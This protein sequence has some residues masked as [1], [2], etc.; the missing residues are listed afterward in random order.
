MLTKFIMLIFLI[1]HWWWYFWR[2]YSLLHWQRHFWW[3]CTKLWRDRHPAC[4]TCTTLIYLWCPCCELVSVQAPVVPR[5]PTR[6]LDARRAPQYHRTRPKKRGA[7][8]CH[9]RGQTSL[10]HH[11]L[12]SADPLSSQLYVSYAQA[13]PVEGLCFSIFFPQIK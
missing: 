12:R 7:L 8:S 1:M 2:H 6:S 11:E 9:D 4:I 3:H 5:H 13:C 10:F